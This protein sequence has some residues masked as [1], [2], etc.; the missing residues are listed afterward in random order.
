MNAVNYEEITTG[1]TDETQLVIT[2]AGTTVNEVWHYIVVTVGTI[3]FGKN[4]VHA[5]AKG[6]TVGDQIPPIKCKPGALYFKA[7]AIT[8]KFVVTTGKQ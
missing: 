4:D 8:D 7:N 1:T 3:K 6:F 2:D 5:N